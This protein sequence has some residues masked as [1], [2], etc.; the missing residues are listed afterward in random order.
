MLNKMSNFGKFFGCAL[1][2]G[3]ILFSSCKDTRGKRIAYGRSELFY[4]ALVDDSTAKKFGDFLRDSLHFFDDAE[5]TVQLDKDAAGVYYFRMVS[6]VNVEN[7]SDMVKAAEVSCRA[8][9]E[10]VLGGAKVDFDFLDAKMKSKRIVHFVDVGKKFVYKNRVGY[11]DGSFPQERA[12]RIMDKAIASGIFDPSAPFRFSQ[13]SIVRLQCVD[14]QMISS[15]DETR[16][17]INGF[18]GTLSGETEGKSVTLE[19]TDFSFDPIWSCRASF[20]NK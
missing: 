3:A 1:L 8:V 2:L 20:D 13:D 5:I 15:S 18:V 12:Q 19:M 14:L 6:G 9:S 7:K 4:T 16:A 11:L 10:E 17:A